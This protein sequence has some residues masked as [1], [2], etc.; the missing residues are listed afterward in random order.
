[1]SCYEV[2]GVGGTTSLPL[3]PC[4]FLTDFAC[5]LAGEAEVPSQDRIDLFGPAESKDTGLEKW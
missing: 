1:M 3:L 5:D 2:G 4:A